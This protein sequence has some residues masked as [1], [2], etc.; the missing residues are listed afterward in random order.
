MLTYILYI[1]AVYTLMRLLREAA[2]GVLRNRIEHSLQHF[3]DA[4]IKTTVSKL[5]G[6]ERRET[7][8]AHLSDV[9]K[10]RAL[11]SEEKRGD[12]SSMWT[13]R[14]DSTLETYPAYSSNPVDCIDSAA[15]TKSA[16]IKHAQNVVS[17]GLE[18]V[19][20]DDTGALKASLAVSSASYIGTPSRADVDKGRSVEEI[21]N[22]GE[23]ECMD[24]ED[25]DEEAESRRANLAM[26]MGLD[27][28]SSESE[29]ESGSE[30]GNKGGNENE[31]EGGS[32]N[33]D[34][35]ENEVRHEKEYRDDNDSDFK[36]E[37]ESDEENLDINDMSD[38]DAYHSRNASNRSVSDARYMEDSNQESHSFSANNNQTSASH[39]EIEGQAQYSPEVLAHEKKAENNRC[40][41]SDEDLCLA[42]GSKGDESVKGRNPSDR[43]S[44]DLHEAAAV[45]FITALGFRTVSHAML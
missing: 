6:R 24:V 38:D 11:E 5:R 41:N 23:K 10:R 28:S 42:T 7:I 22:M 37:K 18:H 25:G 34:R 35:G 27:G 12:E 3:F 14:D 21:G 33:G 32:E 39:Q 45:M 2:L 4:S 9:G 36:H 26:M 16:I 40:Y 30:D 13:I 17:E 20:D 29:S 19:H 31:S 15:V 44:K 8:V 43:L 1:P